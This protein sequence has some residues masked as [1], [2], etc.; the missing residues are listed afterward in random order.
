[1]D[2][3]PA[4]DMRDLE[5]MVRRQRLLADFGDFALRSDDLDE[6]LT[7][8]CRLVSE[9]LGTKHA[10]VLEIEGGGRSIL[11]RAGVG[12][13]SDVAGRLR[14]EMRHHSSETYSIKV[15]KPVISQDIHLEDRFEVPAFL[16][17]AGVV[18]LVNVPIFLPGGRAYGLLQVDGREPRDFGEQEIEFLRTYSTILGPV[19]DRL[20]KV[21][22]LQATQERFRLVVE[23]A[24]DYAIFV[25]D[26]EDRITDWFPGAEAVFG[27]T[28]VE[29]IGQPST[30]LFTPE[31]R[32]RHVDE[33]EVETAR[34]EG[35]APN[36]RWHLRKDG[37]RV[38]IDG[39]V[40]AL[41]A[42]KG[43]VRGFLKIGQDVTERRRTEEQLYASEERLRAL[44]NATA[45]VI[46][47]MSA[48]WT[49]MRQLDGRPFLSDT[50]SPSQSWPDKYI[51]PEDQPRVWEAIQEA[52]STKSIFELEH[53]VWRMDGSL[54]WTLSRAVPLLDARGEIREW[55]GAAS[56]VTAR[57]HAEEA[58]RESEA[59][60]RH[61]ADSAPALIWMTDPE[62]QVNF[63]NMHHDHMFGR[64]ASEM[65]G[66]GWEE[67]VLPEDLDRHNAAFLRAFQARMPFRTETRVRDR[68]GRVIWLRCEG[69]PRMDDGGRFLGYTGC[70]VDITEARLAAE[71]LERRV[72]ER[73]TE[74]MAAEETLRQAQK[75]EAVGQLTGGIAHDFNNMLQGVTGGLG[76]ARRRVAEGRVD[77]ALRY[78]D[79]VQQAAE[80][81]AGLTRRLLAFARRR[82]LE[83]KPVDTDGLVA[84]LAD[85]IHRTVGPGIAL[86]LQLRDGIG[87]VLCDPNELE[88]ALLNLCINARDAMP[89]GGRLTIATEDLRLSAADIP[90][91]T[92]EPGLYVAL[93]VADTGMG[94][95]P[96]VL[97]RVFEPFFTTKPLGQGTGLGLSQVWSFVRQ[98]G[99]L[100]RV[101]SAPGRGTTVRLLLPLHEHANAMER[102]EAVPL[103]PEGPSKLGRCSWWTTR[104]RRGSRQ[105]TG[106]ASWV[107]RCWRRE[108]GLKRSASWPPPARTCWSPTS[109]CRTA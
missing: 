74:L 53:R 73:T 12:W 16:K 37:V 85:L 23:N 67:I 6:V 43:E 57:R 89:E 80:R 58:L 61:M 31:D 96:E 63:T 69:V 19:I 102:P 34:A 84:G 86:D 21:R 88:S 10:K 11:V 39:T 13:P 77:E 3:H 24:L 48:D 18:A 42:E 105:P 99:G 92:A 56:D 9:A 97:E 5:Q 109:G 33:D 51:P 76:M 100:V 75:M 55:F 104:T 64:P 78:L 38:F 2:P 50:G 52:I 68:E 79:A 20:H 22:R 40:T 66:R 30:I 17:D 93:S 98:S 90:D 8:A 35:V 29:A 45:D 91:D 70:N 65:L 44:V 1:M 101:Q 41:R 107:T 25:S 60:F 71:E 72:A 47:A 4:S 28:A 14:M 36:R 94:I 83:P 81:A 95:P 27:W 46:Y 103:A 108:T 54:G 26:A 59:R 62:G 49:E 87:S 106:C 82:P 32:D 7:E 15:G